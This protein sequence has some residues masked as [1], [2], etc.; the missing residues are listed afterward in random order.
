[1][2][3]NE[4]LESAI[5]FASRGVPVIPL[6][7]RDK[8][9]AGQLVPRGL[10]DGSADI[11]RIREWASRLTGCNFGLVTGV[12]FDVIDVDGDE[13]MAALA[14]EMPVD[15]PTID[16]PTV[17]TG[18]GAHVY[19]ASSGSGN[20]ARVL[21]GV[22]YRGHGGYVVCP[23]SIHP[24]G[25]TYRWK[26]GPDDPD[27]G[28]DAPIRP[29]PGWFATLL[30][31]RPRLA[32]APAEKRNVSAYGR[33]ALESEVGRVLLAPV[34]QRN[35][36]LNRSAYALGQL[37]AGGAIDVDTVADALLVAAERIGLEM[38]ETRQTI[39]SGLRG[40]ATQ[41]RRVAS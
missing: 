28:R 21:P 5:R 32:Q 30:A 12:V 27:F 18:K 19:V 3:R 17:T 23:G 39:A 41:P 22:D 11:D 24:S 7:V 14:T 29:A 13:G 20:R 10:L 37:V 33:R 6:K 31:R 8:V 26:C 40:G 15:A 9:P 35:D 34:G 1:M 36:Q 16:G 25:V 4:A 38:L 2:A